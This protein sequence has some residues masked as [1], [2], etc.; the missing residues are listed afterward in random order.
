MLI[1]LVKIGFHRAK[2]SINHQFRDEGVV[3]VHRADN[4][5]VLVAKRK[6][7]LNDRVPIGHE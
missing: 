1:D 7:L 5:F 4:R 6:D 3:D 2:G